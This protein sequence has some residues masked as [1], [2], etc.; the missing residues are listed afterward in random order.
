MN[1]DMWGS[2][3]AQMGSAIK[4]ALAG[5]A[6]TDCTGRNI[7]VDG[8]FSIRILAAIQLKPAPKCRIGEIRVHYAFFTSS[9]L[10]S[11]IILAARSCVKADQPQFHSVSILFRIPL[12]RA[13]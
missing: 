2:P 11:I 3:G 4:V 6:S 8:I 10:D 12:S 1:W 7:G 5:A 13:R 9:S